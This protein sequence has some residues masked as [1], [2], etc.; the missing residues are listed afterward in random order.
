[1]NKPQNFALIGAAGYIAQRPL[2]SSAAST[3]HK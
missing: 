1:M 3:K 2:N